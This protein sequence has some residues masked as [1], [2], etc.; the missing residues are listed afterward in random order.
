M[1]ILL[2][3]LHKIR[4]KQVPAKSVAAPVATVATVATLAPRP[5]KRDITRM[6]SKPPK[7]ST[8]PPAP[9]V[10]RQRVAPGV[11]LPSCGLPKPK[12]KKAKPAAKAKA[13]TRKEPLQVADTSPPWDGDKEAYLAKQAV[14]L[15]HKGDPILAPEGA[16]VIPGVSKRERKTET[17]MD[18]GPLGGSLKRT[19]AVAVEA[20]KKGGKPAA[21][22]TKP[23]HVKMTDALFE[24]LCHDLEQGIT[25]RQICR[26]PDMPS[27]RT[28]YTFV[29][30]SEDDDV[31]ASRSARYARA[32]ELGMEALL[33]EALD[34][35]DDGSNDWVE[36]ERSDGTMVEVVD[37]D[38]VARSKV[39][40]ETRFKV[41]A[42][43]NPKRFGTLVKF[44][45]PDGKPMEQGNK[46]ASDIAIDIAKLMV[47]AA[48][49][50][51]E[52]PGET[53]Q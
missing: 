49:E 32:R 51:G 44:G 4:V 45:D 13:P 28:V 3:I 1:A 17:R 19:I 31:R 47:A 24:A 25:L 14:L 7:V 23:K 15:K 20:A 38:H 40:I 42:I 22:G 41:L 48:R 35:A 12:R 11:E 6:P 5:E 36:R 37:R 33:E 27:S 2:S 53:L 39:R 9:A 10:K 30:E 18:P 52:A 21:P 50:Q 43:W 34:I 46:S 29:F 8:L 26:R 16:T